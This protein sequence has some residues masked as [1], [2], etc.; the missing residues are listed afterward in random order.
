MPL[1]NNTNINNARRKQ[2][3]NGHFEISQQEPS[4]TSAEDARGGSQ[5]DQNRFNSNNMNSKRS[6]MESSLFSQYQEPPRTEPKIY[7]TAGDGMGGRAGARSWDF[8]D[9]ESAPAEKQYGSR[10][11]E[12]QV[13]KTAGNGMG[14]RKDMASSWMIGGP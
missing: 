6:E 14:G 11:R 13:Y 12:K 2:D 3:M 8:G 9:A 10:G 5:N 1:Q 7:K 4:K